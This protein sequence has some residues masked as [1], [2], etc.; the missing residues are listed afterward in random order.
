MAHLAP[1]FLARRC[2]VELS[3]LEEL[4]AARVDEY[5]EREAPKTSGDSRR[6]N[7]PS[8]RLKNVQ[9]ALLR[10]IFNR[11]RPH[12]CTACVTGRGTHWAYRRHAEHPALLR[13]DIEKFFPSVKEQHAR[14]G[15]ARLGASAEL[16]GLLTRLITLPDELPQGA[17]TSVAVADTVL[18]PLDVR[19]A[20]LARQRGLTYTRYVDDLTVSGGER[21]LKKAESAILSIPEELGWKLNDKG[22][23]SGPRERHSLLGA[24]VNHRPNVSRECFREIRS[25]LRLVA[26]GRQTPS[27]ED[28]QRIEGK[29]AWILSVNEDRADALVPLLHAA[30]RR[31]EGSETRE[32]KE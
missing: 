6:L 11:L 17:P 15:L 23:F 32:A 20:G 30:V 22:G 16:A 14:E 4:A 12:A 28:F 10:V 5:S 25:Y 31:L 2:G 21:K 7:V 8:A 29:V 9:R 19:L 13:L 24:V 26:S 1:A 27:R 18:F 3:L